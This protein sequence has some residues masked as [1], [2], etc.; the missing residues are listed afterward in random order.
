VLLWNRQTKALTG[1]VGSG[2]ARWMLVAG[3]AAA[4]SGCQTADLDD[5]GKSSPSDDTAELDEE[6]ATTDPG[7]DDSTTT[8]SGGGDDGGTGDDSGGDDGGGSGGDAG[9]GGG[10]DGTEPDPCPANMVCVDAF[11]FE[12]ANNTSS[13]AS[14]SFDAYGCAP[15]TNESGPEVI[16]RVDLAEDGFL[17]VDL[18]EMADGA[19]VDVHIL[20]SLDPDDCLDR[21]HWR[22]GA[23]LPAGRYYVVADTWVSGGGT[24]YDGAYTLTMGHTSAATLPGASAQFVEVALQAFDIAWGAQDTDSFVYSMTDWSVHSTLEREWVVDLATGDLLFHLHTTHGE[25]SANDRDPGIAESFS[26][27]PESHQSS[28]GMMRG[29]ETYTGSYGYS[30]RLDGLESGYNDNVRSRAIVLHPWEYARPEIAAEYG[31]LGLSWGCPAVDD[32]VATDLIN[33]TDDG[34][35]FFFYYDDGDWS[36]YSDYVLP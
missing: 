10:D 32:R 11:P 34:S 22:S 13:A 27:I 25:A 31:M 18:P 33:A 26:N 29:G 24:E 9:D 30:M 4:F 8:D 3:T 7:G 17:A 2:W 14:D 20:G 21:G 5:G 6:D 23:W 28:L 16:Y 12:E 19:D 36:R 1:C 35:L 15:D